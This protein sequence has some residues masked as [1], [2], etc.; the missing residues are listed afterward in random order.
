[1]TRRTEIIILRIIFG[2]LFLSVLLLIWDFPLFTS[3]KHG[4]AWL[5]RQGDAIRLLVCLGLPFLLAVL[6]YS[7]GKG[8][9]IG[10][11]G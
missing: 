9:G 1:M 7:I 4:L 11:D 8:M 10:N 5:E 6:S 2:F 3:S